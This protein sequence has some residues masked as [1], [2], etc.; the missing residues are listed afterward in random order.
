[1]RNVFTWAKVHIH[2]KYISFHGSAPPSFEMHLLLRTFCTLGVYFTCT[3]STIPP[4][5][6]VT[7][8]SERSA[9]QTLRG[10]FSVVLKP[11]LEVNTSTRWKALAEIY[12]IYILLQIS[13]RKNSKCSSSSHNLQILKENI[14][15]N[16]HFYTIFVLIFSDLMIFSRFFTDVLENTELHCNFPTFRR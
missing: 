14:S 1:M 12:E 6:D 15:H 10:T 7:M 8:W 9:I 5:C 3:R 16:L 11:I 13:N 2:S 4:N